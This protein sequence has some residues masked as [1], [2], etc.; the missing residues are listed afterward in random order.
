SRWTLVAMMMA[1]GCGSVDKTEIGTTEGPITRQEWTEN[2]K[3]VTEQQF[4][5]CDRNR[6]VV[7]ILNCVEQLST[8]QYKAHFGYNNVQSNTVNVPI[9]GQNKFTPGTQNRGQ[10][11]SF[12]SGLHNEVFT[13]TFNGSPLTWVLTSYN[14]TANR[15]ST[16]CRPQ[17]MCPA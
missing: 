14:V 9:G 10:P 15:N 17:T 11:T 7:P 13:V 1:A 16:R 8:G 2:F 5:T 6:R 12:L 3:A 4:E